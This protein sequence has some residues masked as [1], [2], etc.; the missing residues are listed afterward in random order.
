M[1]LFFRILWL[2]R[3]NDAGLSPQKICAGMSETFIS[4]NVESVVVIRFFFSFGIF[5]IR[6]SIGRR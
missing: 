2:L 5:E 4:G 6:H 3:P 1:M